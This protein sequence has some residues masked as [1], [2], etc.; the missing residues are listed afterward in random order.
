HSGWNFFATSDLKYDDLLVRVAYDI[1][2]FD[3]DFGMKLYFPEL[4]LV[5]AEVPRT[6]ARLDKFVFNPQHSIEIFHNRFTYGA[7]YVLNYYKSDLL[8]DPSQSEHRLGVY[9]QDEFDLQALI[10]SAGGSF[11]PMTVTAGLRF[12]YNSIT[13]HAFSPRAALVYVPIQNH[14][15]RLGYARA[16]LKPTFFETS[17]IINLDDPNNLGFESLSMA[18]PDLK[19]ETIDSLEFGYSGNFLDNRLV[20]KLDLAYNWYRNKIWFNYDPD[21]MN[22]RTVGPLSVPDLNGP[23]FNFINHESGF[24]G[25]NVELQIIVR[26][27]D[28]SRLFVNVGYRQIFDMGTKEFASDESVWHLAAGGDLNLAKG[29][30]ASV[31]AFYTSSYIISIRGPGGALDDQ[32]TQTIPD[33]WF[34]NAR[35]AWSLSKQPYE[36]TVGLEAFNLLNF[37]FREFGGISQPN[38]PDF[39]GEMLGRRITLFL[40]GEM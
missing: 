32:V 7:E 4:D 38:E 11:P 2:S 13:E 17:L 19:N 6:D 12:D 22:Y 10:E 37:R 40:H 34:L 36:L 3:I 27:T 9:V 1:W 28:R 30:T 21:A 25:H 24:D 29:W 23:G 14:S 35:V 5:L 39:G 31:R 8:V 26:P 16:F 33:W 15:L 20:L 18:S